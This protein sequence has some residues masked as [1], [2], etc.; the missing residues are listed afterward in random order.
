MKRVLAIAASFALIGLIGLAGRAIV[1][2]IPHGGPVR[3][4]LIGDSTLVGVP[5]SRTG[6]SYGMAKV[7]RPIAMQGEIFGPET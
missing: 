4:A 1:N 5:T 2:S 7:E 3:Y 6:Q